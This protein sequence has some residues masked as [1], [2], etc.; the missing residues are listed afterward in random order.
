MVPDFYTSILRT[1]TVPA[2]DDHSHT[3]P[4]LNTVEECRA[5]LMRATSELCQAI[6]DYPDAQLEQEVVLPFNGGMRLTMADLM[7]MHYW[8]TVYHLG[9]INYLQ[10]Q[11]GD[12]E[13]H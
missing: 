5:H 12:R 11:W 7:G 3:R 6:R 10:T 9:Q 13:M 8:N 2:F 4:V 1:G